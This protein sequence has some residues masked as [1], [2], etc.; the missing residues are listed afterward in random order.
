MIY[1]SF[2]SILFFSVCIIS[3]V[4]GILVV[5][6]NHKAPA[7]RCFFAIIISINF[8]S[9]GLALANIAP[10]TVTCE[11]WRRFSAIGWGTAYSI[12]LHFILIIVGNKT[13]LKKWWFYL[14]LYLP[15]V[16]TVFAYA[17]PSGINPAPYKLLHTEFGWTNVAS[18]NE[19]SIWDWI[20]FVYYIGYAITGLVI[21]LLWNRKAVEHSIKMQS[22][23]I[24]LSFMA[25]L[26]LASLTDLVFGNTLAKLPQMAPIILLIPI[27]T[28]YHTIKKYGFIVSKPFGKKASYMRIIIS[29]ILYLIFA[30]LHINI[31]SNSSLFG[32]DY[33]GGATLRGI[34][35]Q[36]Q[37][38]IS[39]YLVLKEDTPGYLAAVLLNVGSILNSINFIIHSKTTEP[40]PGIIS[41]IGVILLV[42]LIATFKKE[43]ASNIEKINNQRKSLE[44]SEKKLFRMAYYDS[45]TGLYNKDWFVEHL[46]KSIHAA[47]R[48]VSLIGVIFIDLDSFKS[49]N[50][51]MG[52]TTGDMLL[53]LMASRLSS[54]LREEDTLARFG[55]DEF[56]IM[57]SNIEK[58][59]DLYKI[60][61]RIMGA[62]KDSVLVQDM[63]YF[64]T[65]SVGV[66]VYPIDGEDSETLIKNADIAMYLAKN[67][68]KNQ[69]IY[70][71]SDIKNGTVKKMKLT[72]NLYRALDK[73]E[74][75]LYYQP[76]IKAE[77]QEI[78][79]F[80]ALLRWNNE[81]Y[82]IVS[83]DVFIPMAEQTGLIRPIGL[84]VFK[85]A[86]EQLKAF[87]SIYNKDI[88][89]SI[90][91]SLEQLKDT[92]IADKISKI[93]EDTEAGAK[94][95]QIE[96]TESIAFNED[97]SVLQHLKDIKNL[98]VSISIDDFGTGFSSFTRLKT[99]PIDL[100]KIDIDFVRGISSGSQKDMAIIRSII[101]IAKNLGIDV[102]AEG[103]ETEEQF[104]FLRDNQCDI[105]QG[106]YFYK[107]MPASEVESILSFLAFYH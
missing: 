14:L 16:I 27:V 39:I 9:A 68:G 100:I 42:V 69:C 104:K 12:I 52:H 6:N 40:L 76:Q 86:C 95:I 13:L 67:K 25:A 37:M 26:I 7:N 73:N 46:N 3:L 32:S 34:V 63:E 102:L 44:E 55:G 38:I 59:E 8:W 78:I 35:T 28:I 43:T 18:I 31:P 89:M 57:V 17:I 106:F 24:F 99:F 79:G 72:N 50:D 56:L 61:E 70:C 93:L 92:G 5:I 41:N 87:Q 11:I 107:P 94:N 64:V 77:T 90:N 71:S 48:N 91:L 84:W 74:L 36:L 105:I 1:S 2:F 45:L 101:Q 49:V 75:F 103:V 10:D 88:C 81:E 30:F 60:C 62:F 54:C 85:T 47:K 51:T 97:H 53:G 83:P 19:Y 66:A 98:G 80:E 58:P 96:I 65:A 4:S 33:F 29:V 21:L 20:F 23:A 22:R 15:A 82:G